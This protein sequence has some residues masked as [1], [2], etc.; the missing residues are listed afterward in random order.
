MDLGFLSISGL[1]WVTESLELRPLGTKI[2]TGECGGIGPVII[3]PLA[4]FEDVEDLNPL[5]T[6]RALL[7]C[8]GLLAVGPLLTKLFSGLI[9]GLL[10]RPK[11]SFL[12][13]G[14]LY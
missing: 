6:R 9:L 5:G 13:R 10:V 11:T 14:K 3:S 4:V 8:V 12:D 2:P 1:D 7:V